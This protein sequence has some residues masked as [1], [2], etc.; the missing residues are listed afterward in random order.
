MKQVQEFVDTETT[1]SISL[2]SAKTRANE[3][4][5]Q[6]ITE[7]YSTIPDDELK[8]LDALKKDYLEKL[9]E[10]T[11][12]VEYFEQM[13]DELEEFQNEL[14]IKTK[15]NTNRQSRMMEQ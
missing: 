6:E 15:V 11:K 1:K 13:C 3:V 4:W 9:G 14:E 2:F 7:K 10:L 12:K 5:L 8:K